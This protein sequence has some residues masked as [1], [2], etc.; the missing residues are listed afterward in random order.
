MIKPSDIDKT[1]GEVLLN[2]KKDTVFNLTYN[3]STKRMLGN[4]FLLSISYILYNYSTNFEYQSEANIAAGIGVFLLMTGYKLGEEFKAVKFVDDF[5][6]RRGIDRLKYRDYYSDMGYKEDLLSK[7][8]KPFDIQ[9]EVK[10]KK[11]RKP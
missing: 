2:H 1:L 6:N 8:I 11:T 10:P 4:S 3:K 5:C 9:E 7:K